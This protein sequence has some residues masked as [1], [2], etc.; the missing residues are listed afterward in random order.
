MIVLRLL[1]QILEVAFV[2][3]VAGSVALLES[4]KCS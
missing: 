1:D 4:A 2:R 3:P